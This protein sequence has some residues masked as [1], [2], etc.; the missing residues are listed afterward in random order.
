MPYNLLPIPLSVYRVCLKL[1]RMYILRF[2][3]KI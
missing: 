3:P 2:C 1:S